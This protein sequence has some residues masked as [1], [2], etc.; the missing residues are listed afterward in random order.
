MDHQIVDHIHVEAAW[1]ENSQAMHFKE[2]RAVHYRL[3]RNHRRIEAFHV[4][5]LQNPPIFLRHIDQRIRF[6]EV[7][8]H[9]LLDKNVETHFQ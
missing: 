8:G 5:H 9:G 1:R 7:Y 4:P 2:K 6:R 3:H